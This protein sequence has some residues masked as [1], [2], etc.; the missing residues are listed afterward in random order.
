MYRSSSARLATTAT[1]NSKE[2]Y[3]L[4]KP[5]GVWDESSAKAH[6]KNRAAGQPFFA[7][8]NSLAGPRKSAPQTTPCANP[9]P[10]KV[11][12]RLSSRCA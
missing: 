4:K 11:R 2:D 12:V 3:N 6:Y 5:D 8:F 10:A 1:N 7:V 9:D